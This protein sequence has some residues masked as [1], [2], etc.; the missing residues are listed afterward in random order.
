MKRQFGPCCALAIMFGPVA[1]LA[2]VDPPKDPP[3]YWGQKLEG[4]SY[5]GWRFDFKDWSDP[6][7]KPPHAD[8][9]FHP[10]GEDSWTTDP[11][12]PLHFQDYWQGREH[13]WGVDPGKY[14]EWT[15]TLPNRAD[16]DKTKNLFVQ[17]IGWGTVTAAPTD[18]DT[19]LW[20]GQPKIEYL[21]EKWFRKTYRF[22]KKP[23]P[24]SESLKIELDGGTG[25]SY[26]ANLYA[27]TQCVPEP[28]T[29]VATGG[30]LTLFAV[31]WRSMTRKDE[32]RK[33][34]HTL[35]K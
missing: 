34:G 16:R 25:G 35:R 4:T 12:R 8:W 5:F 18:S 3:P 32:S 14:G 22:S 19:W 6:P 2:D 15:V 30:V 27:G 11:F 31:R 13:V 7:W 23:Q 28:G 21:S 10:F 24:A 9:S 33:L 26:I 17:L 20:L 29:L 1:A